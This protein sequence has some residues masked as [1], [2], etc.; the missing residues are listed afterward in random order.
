M[1]CRRLA[2]IG[3]LCAIQPGYASRRWLAS[4]SRQGVPVVKLKDVSQ[5]GIADPKQ[6]GRAWLGPLP[7]RHLVG[8]V[9]VVFRP[10]GDRNTAAALDGRFRGPVV[11]LI[12]LFILRPKRHLVLPEYL[13]WAINQPQAQRHFDR[14]ARGTNMRMVLRPGIEE[15]EVALPDLITQRRIVAIDE[16]AKREQALSAWAAEKR[17]Q[18]AALVLGNLAGGETGLSP[19]AGFSRESK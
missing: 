3:D 12:P 6:L 18:L 14:V 2:R 16:L 5:T 4:P 8:K 11:A 13:A 19:G 1:Q 10:R 15:L 9:D 17:S 7:S